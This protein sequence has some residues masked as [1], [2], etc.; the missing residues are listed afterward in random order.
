MRTTRGLGFV[1]GRSFVRCASRTRLSGVGFAVC[2]ARVPRAAFAGRLARTFCCS[3]SARFAAEVTRFTACLN[4][5]FTFPTRLFV[6]FARFGLVCLLARFGC[7]RDFAG[8]RTA[9]A[10]FL[11]TRFTARFAGR[12]T[13]RLATRL[14]AFF[15]TRFATT[16]LARVRA[17]G[18]FAGFEAVFLRGARLAM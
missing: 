2:G 14:L 7:E 15:A 3:V 10:T 13:T 9:R 16:R 6:R 8:L 5:R 12:F 18:F 11:L 4:A 17:F 1:D